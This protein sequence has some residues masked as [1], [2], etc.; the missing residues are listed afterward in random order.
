MQTFLIA[1]LGVVAGIAVL[2]AIAFFWIRRKLRGLGAK[3]GEAIQQL[4][5]GGVPPFSITLKRGGPIEW[6]DR[7]QVGG[8]SR[9]FEST[10]YVHVDDYSVPEMPDVRLRALWHPNAHSYAV[11]Y[12]HDTAGVFADV[13]RFFR[14]D[15][16][17]TVTSA[18]ETGMTYPDNAQHLRLDV[19][20]DEPAGAQ[21]LHEAMLSES[22]SRSAI[23]VTAAQ[24]PKAFIGAFALEMDWRIA[25]GGPTA[26]EIRAAASAGGQE[27]PDAEAIALIQSAWRS[28]ISSHHADQSR[29]VFLQ[30]HPMSAQEWELKRERIRIINDWVEVEGLADEL[31]WSMIAGD[32]DPDDDEA[33]ERLHEEAQQ[34]VLGAFRGTTPRQGFQA[35]QALLPEKR[36]FEHLARIDD[37]AG[38]VYLEPECHDGEI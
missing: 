9:H 1:M 7:L 15:S 27:S 35:A 16:V 5:S 31:A 2:G 19:D 26:D 10:G 38:D 37:P 24:F 34:R 28:A 13:V 29:Q 25:R 4:A 12:D 21:L 18:P 6:K 32:Y 20:L 30:H 22:G 33:E 23:P 14:N 36:R 11:V 3:L 17:L 8:V